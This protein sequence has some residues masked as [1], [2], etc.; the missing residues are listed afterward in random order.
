LTGLSGGL[1][2]KAK[3][4]PRERRLQMATFILL[5]RLSPEAVREPGALA[6][7]NR[8][9]AERIRQRCPQ[10]RWLGNYAILGPYDYLDIFEAPDT[11]VAAQ[12]SAIVRTL[13]HATTETWA[14]IPWDR[15]KEQVLRAVSS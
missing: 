4:F 10:V 12:V 15:F 6:E 5:T 14:A 8:Q 7:L 11:E 9:V 3:P 1:N 2:V 13:G